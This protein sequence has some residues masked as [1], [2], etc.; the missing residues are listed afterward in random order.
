PDVDQG[1]RRVPREERGRT[2]THSTSEDKVRRDAPARLPFGG[3]V[4]A[5]WI[6]IRSV[7]STYALLVIAVVAS[8][9]ISGLIAWATM[10]TWEDQAEGFE[11]VSGSLIGLFFGQIVIMIFSVMV[12]S[13]EYTTGSIRSTLVAVPDRM[14]LV[15]AKAV[16][17]AALALAAGLVM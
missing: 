14:V 15:A 11:P 7:R 5:E 3:V 10:S 4:H 6:K 9:A 12:I 2:M 16:I 8:V 17:T 1:E 13:S